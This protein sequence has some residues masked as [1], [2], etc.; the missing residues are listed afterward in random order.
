MK[1]YA[2]SLNRILFWPVSTKHFQAFFDICI[3]T[4][5]NLTITAISKQL[6]LYS[7]GGN[8]NRNI[9]YTLQ[10]SIYFLNHFILVIFFG[11]FHMFFF[12]IFTSHF[13][14]L[15][16]R[17]ELIHNVQLSYYYSL[18]VLFNND[19]K[20]NKKQKMFQKIKNSFQKHVM[21][22]IF[23]VLLI[24]TVLQGIF[25]VFRYSMCTGLL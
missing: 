1:R 5:W 14:N 2:S 7:F 6:F 22:C 10:K 12:G 9:F 20:Q 11:Y 16:T 15:I 25:Q 23:F 18:H 19:G 13:W 3:T 21:L 24:E 4:F 17:S 8:Q